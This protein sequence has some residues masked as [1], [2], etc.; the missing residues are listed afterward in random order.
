M[1]YH[2]LK[3]VS[4]HVALTILVGMLLLS[5]GPI[6]GFDDA[7]LDSLARQ[8]NRIHV[9]MRAAF[10]RVELLEK[11]LAEARSNGWSTDMDLRITKFVNERQSV[12]MDWS[13][14]AS[15]RKKVVDDLNEK[16]VQQSNL[17]LNLEQKFALIEQGL[18]RGNSVLLQQFESLAT[19]LSSA[20]RVLG[21]LE[22]A[23]IAME[24]NLELARMMAEEQA[25]ADQKV[26]E[27]ES[28]SARRSRELRDLEQ[29]K[30]RW[31]SVAQ[32]LRED[33]IRVGARVDAQR[34]SY[35]L[36]KY[37][38]IAIEFVCIALLVNLLA[39]KI[40][41]SGLVSTSGRDI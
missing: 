28:A 17:V 33:W 5:A 31:Q 36:K 7:A 35:I 22:I 29:A 18:A 23:K 20:R 4:V 2:N 3:V 19:E 26:L 14:E 37:S 10:D 13:K 24:G 41:A 38:R 6:F 34:A 9:E 30:D 11:K 25:A 1:P 8:H 12:G 27:S 32:N 21:D 15:S 39:M 40:R 16:I